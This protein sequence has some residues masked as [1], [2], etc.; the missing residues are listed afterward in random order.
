MCSDESN[1]LHM[2]WEWLFFH[3]SS[4]N[5]MQHHCKDCVTAFTYRMLQNLGEDTTFMQILQA[6]VTKGSSYV[7]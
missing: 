4:Y 7:K 1:Q 3:S 5:D 2:D 6:D